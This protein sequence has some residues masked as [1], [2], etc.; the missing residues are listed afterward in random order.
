M[1]S[2][3]AD[4]T[5]Y[6]IECGLPNVS[7]PTCGSWDVFGDFLV[8]YASEETSATWA[9]VFKTSITQVL[10]FVDV[11]DEQLIAFDWD[12]GFRAGVGYHMEYDQWDT[13]LYDSWFQTKAQKSIPDGPPALITTIIPEFF[14][15]FINGD[16]ARSASIKWDLDYN[17]FDW[18]LGRSYWVSRGL[19]LRPFIGLK[20]GW[21]NQTIHSRWDLADFKATEDLKNDFWGVGPS[22]GINTKWNLGSSSVSFLNLFG[23]FSAATMWG[24]WKCKD[25]YHNPLPTT[26]SLNLEPMSLGSLMLRGFMGIGWDVDFNNGSHFS[27]RAGF[28][29]QIWINQLR[30]PTLQQL[31]LHGDLTLQGGTFNCRL[32]F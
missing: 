23:D 20:G 16:T 26:I 30:I 29:T 8:W 13:Q 19:S 22:G 12:Y 4:E 31:L 15:G 9:N 14:N 32:D 24:T 2:S 7:Q 21:I 11:V 6:P 25:V 17:M 3:F 5:S 10:T 18:E 28:E 1:L 27:T